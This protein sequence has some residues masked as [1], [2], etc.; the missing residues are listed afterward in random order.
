MTLSD[1]L[2]RNQGNTLTPELI[3]GLLHG[4]EYV[5]TLSTASGC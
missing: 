5:D 1:L 3:V 2:W 4:A